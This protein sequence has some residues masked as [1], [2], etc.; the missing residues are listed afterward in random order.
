MRYWMT[1]SLLSAW[2][3]YENAD[4]DRTDGAWE[5]FLSTLRRERKEKTQPMLDG[6]RFESMVNALLSGE[7]FEGWND[8]WDAGARRIAKLCAGGQPQVPMS[9]EITVDGMDFT[10]YGIA[11]YLKAGIIIDIKKVVRYEYGKYLDSPQHPMYFC[12]FHNAIR[13]DYLIF[14]GSTVHRETYRPGDFRPIEETIFEFIRFLRETGQ[15]GTYKEMWS[16]N[17]KRESMIGETI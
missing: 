3:Y 14:D 8:K 7:R 15:I 1:Q 12:L 10:L 6:I 5:S 13:F 16:M 11:D 17:Q 9:G 2:K 4:D